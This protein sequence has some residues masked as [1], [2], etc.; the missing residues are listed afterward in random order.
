MGKMN[1]KLT[2]KDIWEKQKRI[3]ILG[4][5][6]MAIIL[7]IGIIAE[8]LVC[9]HIVIW[10]VLNLD[11]VS[12]IILQI[13][14][15]IDTLTIALLSLIGSRMDNSYMGIN[16]NDYQLNCKPVWLKE[17]R[18]VYGTLILL[19]INIILH[20]TGRYNLVF[21]VFLITFILIGVSVSMI[22][23]AF[24]EN[25]LIGSEIKAY[26]IWTIGDGN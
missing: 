17:K 9:K 10:Q 12:L 20:M 3:E 22:Y 1:N 13:Q 18:I 16:W 2:W 5:S 25:T 6:I 14:A 23:A 19:I 7:T 21:A 26:R 24:T 4:I 8:A 15:T 11:T